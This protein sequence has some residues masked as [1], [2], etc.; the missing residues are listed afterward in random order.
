[1]TIPETMTKVQW[2]NI[3]EKGLEQANQWNKPMLLD[4]FKD[5]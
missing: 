2:I 4:F 3:Y 1:M 5:G